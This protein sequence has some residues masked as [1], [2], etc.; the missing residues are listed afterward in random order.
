[1]QTRGSDDRSA[2]REFRY[3]R[4]TCFHL[5]CS[6]ARVITVVSH[7]P[8][9]RSMRDADPLETGSRAGAQPLRESPRVARGT[10]IRYQDLERRGLGS[11]I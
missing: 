7:A 11:K 3:N 4:E 2:R 8:R 1:M 5:A 10:R 9:V 6:A